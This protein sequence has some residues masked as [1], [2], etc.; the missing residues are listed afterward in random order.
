MKKLMQKIKVEKQDVVL[1]VVIAL[2]A[3]FLYSTAVS[4]L[5]SNMPKTLEAGDIIRL[6]ILA[7]D[8]SQKE[9]DL[10]LALRDGIWVHVESILEGVEEVDAAREAIKEN[11]SQ[12]EELAGQ[13]LADEGFSHQVIAILHDSLDFPSI[14]YGSLF[15]PRGGYNAL[16]IIIGDG[17]GANWWCIMFPTMCLIDIAVAEVVAEP[18]QQQTVIRPRF[19]L[20]SSQN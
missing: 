20:F 6:H 1:A 7:Q 3:V 15:L 18:Q 13:I 5:G 14:L 9:Q 4:T 2:A 19:R 8:D 16:Q 17:E 12:I 10:K 11:L